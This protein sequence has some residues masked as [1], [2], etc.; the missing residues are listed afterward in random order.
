MASADWDEEDAEQKVRNPLVLQ[1]NKAGSK[2]K[3][4]GT[5]EMVRR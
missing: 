4:L 1:R 5:V 3:T 2:W